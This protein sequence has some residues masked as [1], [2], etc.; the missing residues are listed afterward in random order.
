MS[1]PRLC[2]ATPCGGALYSQEFV[3]EETGGRRDGKEGKSFS[4]ELVKGARE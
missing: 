4:T 3:T 1:A 2:V